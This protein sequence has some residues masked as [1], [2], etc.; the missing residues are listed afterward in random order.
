MKVKLPDGLLQV[1]ADRAQELGKPL[2]ELWSEAIDTYVERNKDMRADAVRTR[3]GI[4]RSSPSLTIEVPEE[5]F[6]RAEK[7]GKRIR[8][9]RDWIYSDALAKHLSYNAGPSTDPHGHTLPNESALRPKR[10]A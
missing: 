6:E 5:L 2:D 3:A 7:L 1:A 10:P 9:Q 4:P 8:K